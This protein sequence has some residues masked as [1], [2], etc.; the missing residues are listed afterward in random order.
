LF[1]VAPVSR[2]ATMAIT[3]ALLKCH[4][5]ISKILESDKEPAEEIRIV[6]GHHFSADE[7]P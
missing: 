4:N 7:K 5:E 2:Q 3:E 6:I 1:R